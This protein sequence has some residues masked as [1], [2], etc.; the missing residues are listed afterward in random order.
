MPNQ[1]ASGTVTVS[2]TLP[3]V[4]ADS[5]NRLAKRQLTNKSDLIRRALMEYLPPDVR[6]GVEAAIVAEEPAEEGYST[7]AKKAPKKKEP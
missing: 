5:V 4:L 1:P 2:F 3:R 6:A 7:V